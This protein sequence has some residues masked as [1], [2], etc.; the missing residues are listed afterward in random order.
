VGEDERRPVDLL[1]DLRQRERL[2]RPRG[3]EE[4]LVAEALP[5]AVAQPL[6]GGGLV[7]GGLEGRDETEVGHS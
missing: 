2:A 4:D 1:D 6:D 3:A 5:D 7:T